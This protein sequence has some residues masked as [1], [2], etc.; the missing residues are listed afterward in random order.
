MFKDIDEKLKA[1]RVAENCIH[2]VLSIKHDA[3]DHHVF[4]VL[5]ELKLDLID[6]KESQQFPNT[7]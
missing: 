1:I 5:A 6:L 2:S 3:V 7:I 4:T